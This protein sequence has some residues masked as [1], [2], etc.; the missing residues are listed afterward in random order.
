MILQKLE[1]E[2]NDLQKIL[3]V[4]PQVIRQ[5]QNSVAKILNFVCLENCKLLQNFLSF[6]AGS[7]PEL[8]TNVTFFS[9]QP[10]APHLQPGHQEHVACRA[11]S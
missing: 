11:V 10:S 5:N 7:S 3:T 1:Q 4:D 2:K 9:E 8:I 6:V